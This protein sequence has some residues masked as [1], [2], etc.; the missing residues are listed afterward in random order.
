MNAFTWFSD[1]ITEVMPTTPALPA[2]AALTPNEP[3]IQSE[4]KHVHGSGDYQRIVSDMLLPIFV[5]LT[6]LT[7]EP[8]TP[9]LNAPDTAVNAFAGAPYSLR[10]V[11]LPVLSTSALARMMLTLP[12]S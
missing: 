11:T 12:A 1:L 7:W 6:T 5:L 9:M 3:N 10:I 8:P 4:R 2:P